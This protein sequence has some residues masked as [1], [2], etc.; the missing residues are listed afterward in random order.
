MNQFEIE[1]EAIN[2]RYKDYVSSSENKSHKERVD[3]VN[4]QYNSIN[5][6]L[7]M[8]ALSAS[9]TPIEDQVV[10]QSQVNKKMEIHNNLFGNNT[11]N[12][13][14]KDTYEEIQ[15]NTEFKN[16][17]PI[18]ST[19]INNE[20][21]IEENPITEEIIDEMPKETDKSETY[22]ESET[23]NDNIIE[24]NAIDDMSVQQIFEDQLNLWGIK[25]DSFSY[26]CIMILADKGSCNM[27]Y[28]QAVKLLHNEIG[29][30][31]GVISAALTRLVKNADFSKSKYVPVLN[32]LSPNELTKEFVIEQLL[33]YCQ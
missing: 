12:K 16:N 10:T 19:E 14:D 1:F 18:S 2:N 27:D 33:E 26:K 32:K 9:G 6:I 20:A 5:L 29:C 8:I 22:E 31:I 17:N 21:S 3:Y 15:S 30:N 4:S 23:I 11:T 25:K 7:K 28:N 24:F 13:V